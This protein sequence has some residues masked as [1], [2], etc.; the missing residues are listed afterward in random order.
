[1][2][3]NGRSAPSLIPAFLAL[4]VLMIVGYLLFSV[5]EPKRTEHTV[6]PPIELIEPQQPVTII[7]QTQ[8]P[9]PEQITRQEAIAFID[10]LADEKEQSITINENQDRFVRHDNTIL[11]PN[12]EHRVTSIEDLLADPNLSADTPITLQYTT[13]EQVASTLAQLSDDHQ[14]HTAVITI[15][16]NNDEKQTKPLFEFLSDPN[17]D[18]TAPISVLIEQEHNLEIKAGDLANV[19]DIDNQQSIVATINHGVQA[20]AIKDIIDNGTMPDNALFYLHRVTEADQQGLW[21][22]IQTGLIDKFREGVHIEGIKYNK[23]RVHA[24]IPA[25][26]DEKLPSGLSSFLGKILNN[27]VTSSYIYNF[28]THVM[29]RDPNRIYPGQQLILI[30]FTS[31]ELT[32]IYQFFSDKRNQE[33]E[34][35]PIAP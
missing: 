4:A 30:H 21:G 1:M 2:A 6:N 25:D 20:L 34:T 29:S 27:K 33:V 3:T 32:D 22:I 15:I 14:D 18:L 16:D 23:D 8:N 31:P 24:I 28:S 17:A 19:T 26:A 10:G 11:L 9:S 35:F 12:L 7:K 5:Q 13:K